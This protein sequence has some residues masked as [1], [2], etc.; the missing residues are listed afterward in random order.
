MFCFLF[1]LKSRIQVRN[2][3]ALYLLKIQFR[4]NAESQSKDTT[5]LQQMVS[6]KTFLS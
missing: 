4:M 6:P 5:N 3:F 1:C 2:A